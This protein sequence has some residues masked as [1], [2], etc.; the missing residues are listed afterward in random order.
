VALRLAPSTSTEV[1]VIEEAPGEEPTPRELGAL[2]AAH[3]MR[4]FG[5]PGQA[6]AESRIAQ[7]LRAISASR[8]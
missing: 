2:H 3:A 7:M 5:D 1:G 8:W 6:P 4:T